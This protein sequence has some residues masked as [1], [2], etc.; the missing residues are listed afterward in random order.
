VYR[1]STGKVKNILQQRLTRP[2]KTNIKNQNFL[3]ERHENST[4]KVYKNSTGKV[5]RIS[6]AKVYRIST[7]KVYKNS[8]ARCTEFPRERCT[9]LPGNDN[10]GA[11]PEPYGSPAA[12]YFS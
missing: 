12:F 11:S 4:A 1:N 8:T 5:Y 2:L 10:P 9:D 6:T 3:L 7:A